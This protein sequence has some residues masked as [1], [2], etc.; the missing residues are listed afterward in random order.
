MLL[1]PLLLAAVTPAP[2]DAE[3]EPD[4][5]CFAALSFA[6]AEARPETRGGLT[7]GLLY[8]MG[9]ID[10]RRPGFDFAAGL[11]ALVGDKVR[12]AAIESDVVRCS[13]VIQE[14]GKDLSRA[15]AALASSPK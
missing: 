9:R 10:A 14:R 11:L 8:F 7:A 13:A 3:I 5:R 6:L 15:G 4:L 1:L 12:L 2:V